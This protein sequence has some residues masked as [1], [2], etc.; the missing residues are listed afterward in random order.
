MGLRFSC[1]L[2]ALVE[3]IGLSFS[4]YFAPFTSFAQLFPAL[5]TSIL[6]HIEL[7]SITGLPAYSDTGYS[8]SFGNSQTVT[9]VGG[10][11]DSG[12][13]DSRLQ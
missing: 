8:D 11:S 6:L 10:Y 7:F 9:V 13:S 2:I 4:P 5:T 12:Y 1:Q 3:G